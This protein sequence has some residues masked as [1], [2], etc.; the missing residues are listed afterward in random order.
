MTQYRIL[1]IISAKER[2][3]VLPDMRA[4]HILVQSKGDRFRKR[5]D[6]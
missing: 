6:Q 2:S 5:R 3:P 1:V 4:P